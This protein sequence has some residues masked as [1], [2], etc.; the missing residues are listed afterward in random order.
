MA[1]RYGPDGRRLF[2]GKSPEDFTDR[3]ARRFLADTDKILT[4]PRKEIERMAKNTE[5]TAPATEQ[6]I[7]LKL[8]ARAYPL[9]EPKGSTVAFAGVTIN[10]SFAIHGVKVI[11]GDKG[12]FVAMPGAKDKNGDYRDVAFPV[13][14][15]ARKQL[16]AVVLDAYAKAAEKDHPELAAAAKEAKAALDKPSLTGQVKDAAKDAK[17]KPAPAKDKAAPDKAEAR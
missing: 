7:P 15:E 3:D 5:K 11:N 17:E 9:D 2:D 10:D 1:R 4:E 14:S 16:G 6:A 13:T 12:M 8:E